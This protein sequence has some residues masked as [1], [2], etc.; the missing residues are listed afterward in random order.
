VEI[1]HGEIAEALIMHARVLPRNR[2]AQERPT[3][4]YRAFIDSN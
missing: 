1:H 2:S 4:G 3:H